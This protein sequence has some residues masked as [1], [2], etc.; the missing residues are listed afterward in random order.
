MILLLNR[1][2]YVVNLQ[3]CCYYYNKV[4][5]NFYNIITNHIVTIRN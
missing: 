3:K 5:C 2:K 1:K 4:I